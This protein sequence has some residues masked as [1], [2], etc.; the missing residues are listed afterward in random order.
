[1][2]RSLAI[3]LALAF[4]IL[5]ILALFLF[6]FDG[7]FPF[8]FILRLGETG[9]TFSSISSLKNSSISVCSSWSISSSALT[10]GA[11][12]GSTFTSTLGAG[13]GVTIISDPTFVPSP[14]ISAYAG[15]FAIIFW[16]SFFVFA[17]TISPVTLLRTAHLPFSSTG[18]NS[19][20]FRLS[21]IS[22]SL[23][24]VFLLVLF[25]S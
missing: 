15:A 13:A 5:I 24:H 19:N 23:D 1:M 6:C 11:A 3:D 7:C 2:G 20:P 8:L 12:S 18:P 14:N 25:I 17:F 10:S 9:W 16:A 4:A 21:I 22:K